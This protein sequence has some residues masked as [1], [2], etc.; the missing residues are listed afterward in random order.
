[1]KFID[2]KSHIVSQ[3]FTKRLEQ[4]KEPTG[5]GGGKKKKLPWLDSKFEDFDGTQYHIHSAQDAKSKL[6]LSVL[7]PYFADLEKFGDGATK[8]LTS[9]YGDY[10]S[11]EKELDYNFSVEVDL[12]ELEE[13]EAP[14]VID[15]LALIKRHA[16]A[17]AFNAMMKNLEEGKETKPKVINITAKDQLWLGTTEGQIQ[18]TFALQIESDEILTNMFLSEIVDT[19]KKPDMQSCPI[20]QLY[21]EKPEYLPKKCKHEGPFLFLGLSKKLFHNE[22]SKEKAIDLLCGFHPYV[23]Y[24]I[25]CNKAHIHSRMRKKLSE[26]LKI[27]NRAKFGGAK[28][29]K[30]K[31]K[32]GAKGGASKGGAKKSAPKKKGKASGKKGGKKGK[33]GGPPPPP[34]K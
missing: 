15:K 25:K 23:N 11:S 28:K 32:G 18:A 17:A 3:I 8:H 14:D 5:G 27:M 1:M 20:V 4:L 9:V 21:T 19:R 24:H 30:G 34:K 7:I 2:P 31:A 26:L 12:N 6:V 29:A 22:Q 16:F 33:K 10:V 13:K